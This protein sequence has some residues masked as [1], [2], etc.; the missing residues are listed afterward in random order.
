MMAHEYGL[1]NKTMS[2]FNEGGSGGIMEKLE[3]QSYLEFYYFR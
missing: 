2:I 3:W 1:K